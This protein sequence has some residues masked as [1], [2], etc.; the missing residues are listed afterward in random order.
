MPVEKKAVRR[1][2][3]TLLEWNIRCNN[4]QMPWKGERD[5]YRI[6]L[7]EIILQQTR[8]EQGLK[9]YD[10]FL[11]A[12]PDIHAL[13][14]APEQ[15]VLKLWEGLG[16]YSR[17]RN[18]VETA[19]HISR[20]CNGVFPDTFKDIQSL[21]GV[22]P[23]TASAIASFAFGL[24]HAVV[25]GNVFRVLARVF[26]LAI[27]TD[28]TEGKKLFT[29]LAADALDPKQPG[30]YN[31]A[32]MDFGA[33]VCRPGIP[34]CAS[35]PMRRFCVAWST[36]QVGTLPVKSKSLTIRDRWF[37]YFIMGNGKEV[38]IRKREARDIWQ[39]LY[40]FPL[41]ETDR[42]KGA[43]AVV[44][45]AIHRKMIHSKKTE[46]V[47]ISE[48][49]HQRLTHQH[50]HAVFITLTAKQEPLPGIVRV[51]PVHLGQYPFP[52]IINSYLASGFTV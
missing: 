23:Y 35:C 34:D 26:G 11:A 47:V 46:K 19:R 36:G 40:E 39:G 25:D 4:R 42:Q 7:S 6:W 48:T 5:P 29:A 27:P 22:G 18:L 1:F 37:Y 2:R 51:R 14:R 49:F 43:N 38:F 44:Q 28:T 10:R 16:Y 20:D 24:P 17:C 41:M 8:V 13:A 31:Q 21:K 32:I 12:F 30:V 33:V 15:K 45:E 50:I 9:Y 3:G 52:R